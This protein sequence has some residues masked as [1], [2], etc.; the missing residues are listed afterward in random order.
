METTTAKPPQSQWL[1][2]AAIWGLTI[3]S[4]ALNIW[5]W[6]ETANGS[7]LLGGILSAAV[8]SSEVLG[9]RLAQRVEAAWRDWP[10]FTLAM[11]LLGGVVAFNAYSGHRAL[12]M[13]ESDRVQPYRE[14]KAARDEA[15]ARL[16]SVETQIAA[17][18][19]ADASTLSGRIAELRGLRSDDVARLEP[20]R[21]AAQRRLDAL[22]ALPAEPA[23]PMAPLVSW[24]I[25]ALIEATKAFGLFAVNARKARAASNVVSLNPGRDLVN[26]RWG[27]RSAA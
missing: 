5:G 21:I 4:G 13:V 18:P 24:L 3:A 17:L 22:P 20:Q 16:R 10:R 27:K 6:V 19:Q 25:V 1:S 8:I 23:A 2:G 9:V 14:A 7:Y 15:T 12:D 26:L 11:G